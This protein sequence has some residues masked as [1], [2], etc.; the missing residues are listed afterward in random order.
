MKITTI[1]RFENIRVLAA[2]RQSKTIH[3]Y[4]MRTKEYTNM[5]SMFEIRSL[6]M[7]IETNRRPTKVRDIPNFN[8]ILIDWLHRIYIYSLT[9]NNETW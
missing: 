3:V 7:Y 9:Q 4:T 2:A 5:Q 6:F 1:Y 8:L